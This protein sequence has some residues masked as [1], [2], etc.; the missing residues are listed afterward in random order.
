MPAAWHRLR[1]VEDDARFAFVEGD[2]ADRG[3]AD[4]ALRNTG[5]DGDRQ[6]RRRDARRPIDRRACGLRPDQPRRHVRAARSGA[7]ST[8]RRT[9]LPSTRGEVPVPACLDRRGL[10]HARPDRAVFGGDALRAELAL[11]GQQGRRRSSRPRVAP[12]LRP[13]D[14]D[15]ELLEQLRSIPVP[16]EAD[17]ADDPQRARGQAAAD[18]RRR[19]ER[20]RLAVRRGS[21]RGDRRW[22]SSAAASGRSTTSAAATS[23]RNIEIVDTI[24][25]KLERARAGDAKSSAG[26]ERHLAATPPLKTFVAD[27]P[28]HDRRY[29]ID[30][31]KIRRELGWT[32]QLDF[33]A[34][35]A[36][37]RSDWYLPNREW[38]DERPVGPLRPRAPG[39]PSASLTVRPFGIMLDL[40]AGRRQLIIL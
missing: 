12:Y 2:I 10:W 28:G 22:R 37:A 23:R 34:G 9:A 15:H 5:A 18:L 32:P 26:R 21:L 39:P 29:A 31:T 35:H 14:A 38:C 16:R 6:L 30:A 8:G 7:A 19:P 4:A 24:C 25:G 17:P 20:A 13:A 11:C 36:S 27:R 33:A 3:G 40:D 1:D